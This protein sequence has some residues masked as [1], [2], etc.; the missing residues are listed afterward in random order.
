MCGFKD[1]VDA[2]Q[3]FLRPFV[4]SEFEVA[5]ADGEIPRVVRA[6]EDGEYA[7]FGMFFKVS[8]IV[9]GQSKNEG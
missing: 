9:F 4:G 5:F 6:E 2:F 3:V 7:D 8:S 1:A